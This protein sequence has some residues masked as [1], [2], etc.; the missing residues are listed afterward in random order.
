VNITFF[1]NT[2]PSKEKLGDN[3]LHKTTARIVIVWLF[4]IAALAYS[5]PVMYKNRESFANENHS[6]FYCFNWVLMGVFYFQ[7]YVMFI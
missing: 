2:C 1:E 5:G 4:I 7:F 6:T 3:I